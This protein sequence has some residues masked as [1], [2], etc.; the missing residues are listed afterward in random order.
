MSRQLRSAEMLREK[1]RREEERLERLVARCGPAFHLVPD[2]L[3]VAK[4]IKDHHPP[5]HQAHIIT[6]ELRTSVTWLKCEPLMTALQAGRAAAVA[7]MECQHCQPSEP[8]KVMYHNFS[9]SSAEC[10]YDL[11]MGEGGTSDFDIMFEFG[12]PFRW[13][14]GAGCISPESAPQ[15]YAE[16]SS[17]PGFVILYWVRTSRCSHEA[18]LA[19][20]P[21]DSIRRLMWY[22]CRARSP[23]DAEITRS[24]PAV[25][26]RPSGADDGGTDHVRCLRLP[27][28]P[29]RDVFLCRRRVTDFPPAATRRDLCRFGVHLVPTGRPGSE[30]EQFEYR[31][32]FSRA[33]VITVRH[34]SP[35]QHGTITTVKGMKNA[36]KDSGATPALKSYYVKTAV[37]WLAQDQPSERWTGI[38]DGVN[39]VLDWLEH[40]LSAGHLPCF[41]WP[42]I[43]LVGGRGMAEIEDIIITVQLMRR[44][45]DILLVACCDSKWPDLDTMLEGGSEPLSEPHLRLRLTGRLVRQAV[46]DG[47]RNRYTAPCWEHWFRFYIP[48][49]SRLSQHRLLRWV[50]RRQSGTYRQQ[51]YLLQTLAVAPAD[52]VLGMRLTP[53]G[54]DMFAWPVTPLVNLLT[55]SDMEYL[56]GEPAAVAAWCRQQL[57]RPPAERPAG[58]TAAL[59]TPRGRA[60]LLLHPELYLRALS[61][62]VPGGRAAWQRLD[63]GEEEECRANLTPPDTY[64]QCREWLENTVRCDLESPLR[65]RLPELDGPTVAATARL[66][67]QNMQHLLSGDRLWEAYTATTRCPDRW[68]LVQHLVTDGTREGKTLRRGGPFT[69]IH[70]DHTLM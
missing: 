69:H 16:P 31:V 37:L 8:P 6:D 64:Q 54:G 15:L 50:Y 40:H 5:A 38:T 70:T 2:N 51:C 42:A 34:L 59:N 29:E 65:R 33:E 43:N 55:Q 28:W 45:E 26:V 66:W 32:S 57:C 68:Q 39:M 11:V 21:A 20:L 47:I 18:P 46:L 25:N 61:E 36:L 9:G 41:F 14:E 49:L 17:S 24:G 23:P 19:A 7:V 1:A 30:T 13:A 60:E 58:L 44:Q 10:L 3:L 35:V 67:R 4:G 12:G 62:A 56:L 27:W 48:A 22:H 63:Q 52:L 53:L